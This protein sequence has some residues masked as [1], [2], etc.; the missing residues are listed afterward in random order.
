MSQYA[1]VQKAVLNAGEMLF[2]VWPVR[3][4]DLQA[5]IKVIR[6]NKTKSRI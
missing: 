1:G 6:T 4:R 3:K 2:F 5:R